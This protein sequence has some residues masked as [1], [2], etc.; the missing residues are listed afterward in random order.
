M[1]KSLNDANINIKVGIVLKK[2]E[3]II[4]CGFFADF[5]DFGLKKNPY[6]FIT[7]K[8]SE[9]NSLWLFRVEIREIKQ[10]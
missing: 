2:F 1:K 3:K 4:F 5:A 7:Q 10:H 6:L 8:L 9:T